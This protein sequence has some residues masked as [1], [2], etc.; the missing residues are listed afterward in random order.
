MNL[1]NMLNKKSKTQETTYDFIYTKHVK[2]AN[3]QRQI[4]TQNRRFELRLTVNRHAGSNW[5][6]E[7]MPKLFYGNGCTT[8]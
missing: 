7:N 5:N 3:L 2:K 1:K 6:D 4:S 8:W